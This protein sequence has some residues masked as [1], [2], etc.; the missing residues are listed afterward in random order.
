L[1]NGIAKEVYR[2]DGTKLALDEVQALY[3]KPITV[4]LDNMFSIGDLWWVPSS[5][6]RHYG[7]K[8]E[9]TYQAFLETRK[10]M[11]GPSFN[12][13]NEK[14][15][16]STQRV[17]GR[18]SLTNSPQLDSEAILEKLGLTNI[19]HQKIFE[20]GKPTK[21][22]KHFEEIR[23]DFKVSYG[24]MMS[25]GDNLLNDIVP[26]KNLGCK[27]IY[28]NPHKIGNNESADIVV[29]KVGECLE[30]LQNLPKKI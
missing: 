2:W 13:F 23:T 3:P 8:N 22:A 11:M 4:N 19:F 1:K 7:L 27:T 29:K 12:M 9:D 28:I 5:I 16:T 24:E 21:T 14:S 18:G 30:I 17:G 26:A 10:F 20:A 15:P 6:G 25:V